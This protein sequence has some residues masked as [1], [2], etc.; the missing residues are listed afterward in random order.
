[1]TKVGTEVIII[2]DVR[3]GAPATGQKA[4]YEGDF[5]ISMVCVTG[6]NKFEEVS[7]E[8]YETIRDIIPEW[9]QGMPKPDYPYAF[10]TDN[11]RM[12]LSDGSEIWGYEC[13]WNDADKTPPLA[14]AQ[15]DLE[16]H[17]QVIVAMMEASKEETP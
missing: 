8:F 5:P 10:P 13:W 3:E 9:V 7:L 17:K 16:L 11:P 1:M 12:R 6:E 15:A 14:E 4:I 2:Q